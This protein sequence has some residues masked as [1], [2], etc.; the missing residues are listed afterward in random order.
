MSIRYSQ[1]ADA[2]KTS[3]HRLPG[4]GLDAPKP[5]T[6]VINLRDGPTIDLGTN[7]EQEALSLPG[8]GCVF[9]AGQRGECAGVIDV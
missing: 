7:P 6:S 2:L 4:V 9:T 3:V 8:L 1:K 5:A